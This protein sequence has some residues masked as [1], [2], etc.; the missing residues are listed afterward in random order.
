MKEDSIYSSGDQGKRGAS[1]D[2]LYDPPTD[3][4]SRTALTNQLN[5]TMLT[6]TGI[7]NTANKQAYINVTTEGENANDVKIAGV[8]SRTFHE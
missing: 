5:R 4:F 2:E 1:V 6:G 3:K 8:M 7:R